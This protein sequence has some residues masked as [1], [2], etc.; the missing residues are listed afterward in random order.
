MANKVIIDCDPGHDDAI[1]LM[2]AIGHP[3]IEVLGVT[4][5]AGNQS[6]DKVTNNAMSVLSA[7]NA[8]DIPVCRGS[9]RPLVRPPQTAGV[10]HGD[11]GLEGPEL[12]KSEMHLDPRHAVQFIIDTVMAYPPKSIT[13]VP[14]GPLTNI[15]I[16]AR[17]EPR[18]IPRVKGIVLMGG[19]ISGGNWS[20]SAEFN[21]LVDPES[22]HIVF[23]EPWPLTMVGIDATHQA[24]A[25][26][27]T[28][29]QIASIGTFQANFVKDLLVY[30]TKMYYETQGFLEPPVHDPCTIAYII[31]P[32]ILK[33]RKMPINVELNGSLTVGMTVADARFP[34]HEDCHSQA[35]IGVDNKRFW[36]LIIDSLK[37]LR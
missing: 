35:A 19:A 1:A 22:A 6:I 31:D 8:T 26:K 37:N 34:I 17:L 12:P 21:I 16:A 33:T 20:A 25:S 5:V 30:F 4:T 27:E 10:L 32:S 24:L 9:E 15:A 18:L 7:A 2:L 3:D 23:N 13:L 14:I 11:S 28:V 29:D 36:A